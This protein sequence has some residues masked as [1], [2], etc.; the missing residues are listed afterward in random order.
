MVCH[1]SHGPKNLASVKVWRELARGASSPTDKK[2]S[3][4]NDRRLKLFT[5]ARIS[6]DQNPTPAKMP[7]RKP[8]TLMFVPLDST[9]A[10]V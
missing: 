10:Y 8:P 7:P 2:A 4:R 3:R 1:Q 9:S 5:D 6:P